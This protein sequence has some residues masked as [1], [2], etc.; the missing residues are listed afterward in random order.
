MDS[1][2]P[3]AT[4]TRICPSFTWG[5]MFLAVLLV[6]V[7]GTARTTKSLSV[8]V[9]SMS[10]VNSISSGIF[11]PGSLLL[12]S[13]SLE[14][15]ST[16]SSLMDQ[17]ITSCP[18][19]WRRSDRAVPQLPAP[20]IPTFAIIFL[21]PGPPAYP[22]GAGPHTLFIKTVHWTVLFARYYLLLPTLSLF[23]VPF[24]RRPMLAL[25]L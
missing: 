23:S 22:D 7:E 18:F 24:I 19:L 4:F 14:S 6:K 10:V 8:T 2:I 15:I 3:F 21:L 12:C 20:I 25:C 1:S 16:S 17:T 9:F 5:H 11:T 13:L